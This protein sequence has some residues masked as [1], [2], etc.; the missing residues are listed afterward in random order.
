[1]EILII[2]LI[3]FHGLHSLRMA[4]PN[5][6][7]KMVLKLGEGPWKG[8]YSLAT[9]VFLALIIIGYGQAWPDAGQLWNV[10]SW[11]SHVAI[12]LM[13]F[14]FILMPFNMRSSR[15]RFI[16]HHPFL[17]SVILWSVAH[18]FANADSA[19]VLLFGSFLVWAVINYISVRKRNNPLPPVA[20][21]IADVIAIIAGIGLWVLFI[22]FAHA[23]LFGVSPI[24]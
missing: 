3:G 24:G 16:T 10:P 20:P 2:G 15:F 23:F 19:S 5:L 14:A 4:A 12:L 11:G 9:L 13:L 6:R 17:L 18:L 7:Q 1:M 8:L 22:V 21:L